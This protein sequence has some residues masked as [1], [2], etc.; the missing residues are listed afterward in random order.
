MF[1]KE[2]GTYFYYWMTGTPKDGFELPT[3]QWEALALTTALTQAPL[4]ADTGGFT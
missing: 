1:Q 4:E 2:L 3:L